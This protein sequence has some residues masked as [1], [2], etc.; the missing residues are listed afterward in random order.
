M[1]APRVRSVRHRLHLTAVLVPREIALS[2]LTEGGLE[3]QDPS[4]AVAKKLSLEGTLDP[5]SSIVC[6]AND[7]LKFGREGAMDPGKHHL[8]HQKPILGRVRDR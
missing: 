4:L 1:G 5:V 3:V 2:K 8:V 7:V 6:H